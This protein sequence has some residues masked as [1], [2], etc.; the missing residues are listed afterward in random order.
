M[1]VP[2]NG[3]FAMASFFFELRVKLCDESALD[4]PPLV[5]GVAN[6]PVRR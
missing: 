2:T 4:A 1:G 5:V 3:T 6:V